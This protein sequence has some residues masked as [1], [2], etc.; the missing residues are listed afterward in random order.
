M[1]P[2]RLTKGSRWLVSMAGL[3]LIVTIAR[4][5][6]YTP[7]PLFNAEYNVKRNGISIGISTRSLSMDQ[8]GV[9]LYSAN[10]YAT[11]IL[12]WF[13]KDTITEQSKWRYVGKKIRPLEYSYKRDGGDKTRHVVL[14]FDWQ[15]NT[16]TNSIDGD[17]WRMD[18]QADTQDKLVYQLSIMHDLL[19]GEHALSYKIA[20]GGKLKDYEFEILGEEQ[21]NTDLGRMK[22]VRIQRMGDK[23]DTTVWCAPQ[24]SYLPIRLEQQDTD[25]SQWTMQITSIRGITRK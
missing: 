6:P 11:G 8:N 18:I 25:G 20:D 24:L 14:T 13:V 23:R 19:N 17:P 2:H 10:T 9:Y 1:P 21:L 3:L 4:A 7:L 16:V 12:A 22:A 15:R 5:A